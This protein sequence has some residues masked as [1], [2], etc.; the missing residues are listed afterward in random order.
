[1]RYSQI[2]ISHGLFRREL[3]LPAEVSAEAANATYHDGIL[4]VVLPKA[5]TGPNRQL[6]IVAR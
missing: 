5:K 3:L 2:E 1:M 4:E 6:R